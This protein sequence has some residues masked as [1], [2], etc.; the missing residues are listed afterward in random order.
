MIQELYCPLLQEGGRN[1]P[2]LCR[3]QIADGSKLVRASIART[4]L[5]TPLMD[6]E[7]YNCE[8]APRHYARIK[9]NGTRSRIQVNEDNVTMTL[10]IHPVRRTD[11]GRITC[12]VHMINNVTFSRQCDIWVIAVPEKPG[13][14]YQV[15]SSQVL[16]SCTTAKVFPRAGCVWTLNF[17]EIQS[18]IRAEVPIHKEFYLKGVRYYRTTCNCRFKIQGSG[19]YR[20]NVSM[21]PLLSD[22]QLT[23][24]EVVVSQQLDISIHEASTEYFV[25]SYLYGNDSQLSSS[26]GLSSRV[27]CH[28]SGN[29]EP[30]TALYFKNR[31]GELTLITSAFGQLLD[32]S[33]QPTQCSFIGQLICTAHNSLN[34]DPVNLTI[35]VNCS[36]V[37][38][39]TASASK[40]DTTNEDIFDIRLCVQSSPQVTQFYLQTDG[41]QFPKSGKRQHNAGDGNVKTVTK[42]N[43]T[44][45]FT[46]KR[47][48]FTGR[49]WLQAVGQSV[50]FPVV[51]FKLQDDDTKE[52]NSIDL[53]QCPS[54]VH[55][56][57]EDKRLNM[58][59]KLGERNRTRIVHSHT[60]S[61]DDVNVTDAATLVLVT[62]T[63]S[64]SEA[65]PQIVSLVVENERGKII[66]PYWILSTST[67]EVHK[68]SC[69]TD[70]VP[71]IGAIVIASLLLLVVCALFAHKMMERKN[72]NFQK[73]E[74]TA[75]D[76]SSG[77][78]ETNTFMTITDLQ[79]IEQCTGDVQGDNKDSEKQPVPSDQDVQLR[80]A[81]V[82]PRVFYRLG[83]NLKTFQQHLSQSFLN[84]YFS[85]RV[86]VTPKDKG[87]GVKAATDHSR[88]STVITD[89]DKMET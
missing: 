7:R 39:D 11:E 25:F 86:S 84:S 15:T 89:R 27:I 87:D 46:V 85:L 13:C 44:V 55:Q 36:N 24:A 19:L 75:I 6:C 72:G 5:S 14:T 80:H 51:E 57:S 65:T 71:H 32:Y 28:T 70:L 21:Y 50:S 1:P 78:P 53:P 16:V 18:A 8:A 22:P 62:N 83:G 77:D 73:E 23:T 35:T 82:F 3:T 40:N 76:P 66:C 20:V 42:E 88:D 33:F 4:D 12:N 79:N 29:P 2:I 74:I 45:R 67:P 37:Y 64:H 26:T 68:P 49:Q 54:N 48:E 61:S 31:F 34:A 47:S 60:M 59:W 58:T 38:C 52:D 10:Q 43:D 9:V 69:C 30:L 81:A 56:S 63:T 41:A 17:R